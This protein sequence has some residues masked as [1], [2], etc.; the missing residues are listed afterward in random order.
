MIEVQALSID[1]DEFHL[2][3]VDLAIQTGEYAVLLGPTGVGKTVLVEC[4]VGIHR[5][6]SGSILIDGRDVTKLYPEERHVGYVP[7]DYALF[8][9]MT[10]EGNIAYGL[11]ARRVPKDVLEARVRDMLDLLQVKH[12]AHRMPLNLSGGERQRVALGRALVTEPRILLLDEP[13]SAVDENLRSELAAELRRIHKAVGGT[14]L[15]V[16]HNL[17]EASDVAHRVAIMNRGTIA[18][19][20]TIE[21]ILDQPTSLFVAQFTRMQNFL[22]GTAEKTADGC[23]VHIGSGAALL[24]DADASGPVVAGV[25]PQH[26]HIVRERTSPCD[27]LLTG[28]VVASRVKPTTLE[29]EIDV[30]LRLIAHTPRRH[31]S[32]TPAV[33]ES[34][35]VHIPP[36]SIMLFPPE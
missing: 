24:A 32:S 30:G 18:Q 12:L 34:I 16:C 1:F 10:V 33:G 6:R 15:H 2:R 29:L 9:N 5:P 26:I 4:I 19:I 17:D 14:F 13:L 23:Q 11:R 25:R 35:A 3:D 8:P 36:R 20:G 22:P 21:D 28:R 7:Q 27:N 31:Q